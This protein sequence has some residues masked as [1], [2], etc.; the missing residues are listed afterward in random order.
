MD[1][2]EDEELVLTPPE[3]LETASTVTLS[4]LPDKSR[5]LYEK[6]YN[7]FIV[8]CQEKKLPDIQ[9]RYY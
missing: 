2:M 7:E 8:W 4:L 3:V 9:S 1:N 5:K 6:T